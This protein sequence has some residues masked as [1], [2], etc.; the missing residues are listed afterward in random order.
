[1]RIKKWSPPKEGLDRW[2]NSPCQY[3][4]KCVKTVWRTRKLIEIV[5]MVSFDLGKELR[6]MFFHLMSQAW[7]KEKVMSPHEELNLRPLDLHSDALPLSHRDS[8]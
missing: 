6:K 3:I 5:E 4:R 7:D 8:S 1:M 2:T